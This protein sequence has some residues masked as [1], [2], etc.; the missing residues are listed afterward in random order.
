[1]TRLMSSKEKRRLSETNGLE[2][3]DFFLGECHFLSG[4]NNES[5]TLL[6]AQND[7]IRPM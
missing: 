5:C 3:F 6:D 7:D 4:Y 1:M 2:A